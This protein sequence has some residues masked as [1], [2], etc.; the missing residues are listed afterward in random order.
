MEPVRPK[1]ALDQAKD[2]LEFVKFSHTIFALPFALISMLVAAR[3][4]PS[5][6]IVGLILLCMISART[7]AMCFNRLVDWDY[8]VENPRTANRSKLARKPVA[9]GLCLVS[10]AIFKLSAFFLN[11]LC[12]VLSPVAVFLIFFYSF[13]KRFTALSHAFLG[14]ALSAAPMG[15]W[16]AVTGELWSPAPWCLAAAVLCWV[17]GFDLIYATQDVDFDRKVGLFSFPA[18]YG[19]PATLQLAR[20]LHGLTWL[21]LLLFGLLAGLKLAYWISL[22]LVAGALV[23]EHRLSRSG[24]LQK[25]NVAFFQVNGAV[26][27]LLLLGVSLQ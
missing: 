16:A 19:L 15:A 18:R 14:L 4:I 12:A 24:D 26:S 13:T 1:P 20:V 9:I 8:D 2:A 11:P 21:I 22:A 25:I 5:W 10:I 6:K 27:L 7:A 3:G 23:Y 17:F